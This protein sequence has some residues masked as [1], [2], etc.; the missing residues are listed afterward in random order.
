MATDLEKV[1]QIAD[2]VEAVVRLL[3]RYLAE[4]EEE[5]STLTKEEEKPRVA[6]IFRGQASEIRACLSRIEDDAFEHLLRMRDRAF[7]L[8]GA[9]SG[10][11]L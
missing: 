1:E 9:R 2:S 5:I 10:K 4:I 7:L 8:P 3:T 6:A 11:L